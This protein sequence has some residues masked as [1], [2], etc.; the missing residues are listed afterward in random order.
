VALQATG[1]NEKGRERNLAAKFV[2]NRRKSRNAQQSIEEKP[3]MPGQVHGG[4][5]SVLRH[6]RVRAHGHP[7]AY[8]EAMEFGRGRA[9]GNLIELVAAED[10]E[11][12]VVEPV[13]RLRQRCDGVQPVSLDN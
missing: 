7:E 4:A 1:T 13:I 5:I 12:R 10:R 9:H 2:A 8:M 3:N 11:G 6:E